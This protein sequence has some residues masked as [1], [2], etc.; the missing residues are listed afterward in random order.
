MGTSLHVADLLLY[1]MGSR[2][3]LVWF[4]NDLR[5]HDNEI[6]IRA[7]ERGSK[8]VPVYFFDPRHFEITEFGFRKTGVFRAS[9]IRQNLIDLKQTFKRF[10]GDLLVLQG[11][12]EEL[13]PQ[14]CQTYQADEVFHHREV[15]FEETQVSNRVEAALWKQQINLRHYIGHTLY[16]KEDL[17][18]PIKDI[19]DSFS[20]FRKKTERETSV[21][22]QLPAPE[23]ILFADMLISGTETT[24]PSLKE[25]GFDADEIKQ[26]ENSLFSGGE[27]QALSQMQS[28]VNEPNSIGNDALLSPYIASGALSPN[29]FYHALIASEIFQKDKKHLDQ[30][31]QK[32]LWRDYYRFMFKKHGNLFFHSTGIKGELPGDY[33]D[34]GE[35]FEAWKEARTGEAEIDKAMHTLNST[36]YINEKARQLTASYL[37]H[38]LNVNW[39]FGAAWFEEKLIDFNPASN[40]GNWAHIAGVGSSSKDNKPMDLSKIIGVSGKK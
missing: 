3:I 17:P 23:T 38:I 1:A 27:K 13:L 30:E 32:L 15:A 24:I 8:I 10:G 40:Y 9:F 7:L 2:T 5:I 4:R 25:L 36:G 22:P 6:L 29:T 35:G 20:V 39:L 33:Q 26:A 14:L 12:P 19:P 18:Y 31:L 34:G 28:Y 11:K 16:H 21:R 37:V